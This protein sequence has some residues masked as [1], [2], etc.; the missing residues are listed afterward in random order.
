MQQSTEG[1]VTA[2]HPGGAAVLTLKMM[3]VAV[4]EAHAIP[5]L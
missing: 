4:A 3:T 1:K 2:A 5:K